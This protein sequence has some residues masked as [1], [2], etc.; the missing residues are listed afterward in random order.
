M[1]VTWNENTVPVSVLSV[2]WLCGR[3][4]EVPGPIYVRKI[5]TTVKWSAVSRLLYRLLPI[6]SCQI[7]QY[8]YKFR[9]HAR[10]RKPAYYGH[11]KWILKSFLHLSVPALDYH[12]YT[13]KE[14]PQ[15]V[16]CYQL[17]LTAQ[18]T[19]GGGGGTRRLR[20]WQKNYIEKCGY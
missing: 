13:V 15:R 7:L 10:D 11:Y 19:S 17:V 9:A 12:E 6:R 14:I 1:T 18:T 3:H 16:L 5:Y 4:G 20:L 8:M 2:N